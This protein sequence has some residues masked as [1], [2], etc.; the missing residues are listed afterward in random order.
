[1]SEPRIPPLAAALGQVP[2]GL[3]ILT[4]GPGALGAGMLA[5]FVQQAGFAPPV[6]TVAVQQDRDAVAMIREKGAFCLNVLAEGE[7]RLMGRFA[8]GF[9]PLEHPFGGIEIG[10]ARN[11]APYIADAHA[12][13]VC[14]VVGEAQWSDHVVFAGEVLDGGLRG[15][16]EP[17]VHVRKTGL[18]Y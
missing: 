12:H 2:S 11:G 9:E 5:S 14:K 13:L 3:F 7:K 4:Y 8:R 16:G 6:V 10:V 15:G 17:M 1:M 18:S